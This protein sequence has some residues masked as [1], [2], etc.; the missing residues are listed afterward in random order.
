MDV[1][2]S[3]MG[4]DTDFSCASIDMPESNCAKEKRAQSGRTIDCS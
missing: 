1:R 2:Q 4:F 3:D